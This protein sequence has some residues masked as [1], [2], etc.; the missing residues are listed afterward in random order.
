MSERP[1]TLSSGRIPG[2]DGIRAIAILIVIVGHLSVRYKDNLARF[3]VF[4]RA[5]GSGGNG[6]DLFFVLSGFLITTLLMREY[7]RSGR[8]SLRGFYLRRA[9]RILP[10]F[11]VYLA[12]I[13]L[14]NQGTNWHLPFSAILRAGLFLYDYS[15]LP[16]PWLVAHTWSLAVEEQFYIFWPLLLGFCLSRWGRRAAVLC[17]LVL[18]GAAPAFRL[19]DYY[20]AIHRFMER[21][22]MMLH[23]RVDHLMFGCLFALLSGTRAFEA[24]YRVGARVWWIF[25]AWFFVLG[26]LATRR[27]GLDYRLLEGLSLNGLTMAAFIVYV[28]RTPE[29]WLGRLLNWRPMAFVGVLSYSIYLWQQLFT[30]EENTSWTGRMPGMILCI[31]VVPAISYYLVEQPMLRLRDRRFKE[32]R[33]SAGL[34]AES[35]LPR[36]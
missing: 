36:A 22:F 18:I 3:G 16:H 6:V 9:F 27:F 7:A 35:V 28:T 25:P 11:Y 4:A 33:P 5:L 15:A 1:T 31:A 19:Y 17:A 32:A 12:V 20:F 8:I 34:A 14:L 30:T 29:T 23:T 10:P 21:D 26:N 24:A 13:L 2:L